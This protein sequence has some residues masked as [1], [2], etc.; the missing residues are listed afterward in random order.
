MGR[1][2]YQRVERYRY[3]GNLETFKKVSAHGETLHLRCV[4][5]ILVQDRTLQ[6]HSGYGELRYEKV[7]VSEEW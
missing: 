7:Q 5:P 6:L 2:V 1:I 4:G 3:G